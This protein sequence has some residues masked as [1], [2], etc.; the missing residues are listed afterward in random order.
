[1]RVLY[2]LHSTQATSGA[3]KALL[4]LIQQLV[5][6]GIT[7][8]FIVP[9][10]EG[11]Y[12]ILIKNNYKVYNIPFKMSIYPNRRCISDKV[13]FIPKLICRTI[14]NIFA[15]IR[16]IRLAKMLHPDIIHTNT[17]VVN[18]GRIAA[19]SLNI[20]HIQHIREYSKY[21]NHGIYFHY[22][23]SW[24]YVHNSMKKDNSCNI[25]ITKDI[26]S[27]HELTHSA[28]TVVVYDGVHSGMQKM[29]NKEKEPYFLYAGRIEYIKGLD[30][31]L[32]AYEH[33][34]ENVNHPYILYV[35]G[36]TADNLYYN[37]ITHFINC[38]QLEDYVHFLGNV[39]K[40]EEL[41]Q[42]AAALIIPSR[43]EG[44]GFCMPEAMFNGC[45]CIGNYVAGTKEQI[46]NGEAFVKEKIALSY[47]TEKELT[48]CLIKIHKTDDNHWNSIK[49]F[50][51]KT[52][53]TLYT[54]EKSA[55]V[56]FQ[57]YNN[58]IKS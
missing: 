2:I 46:D 42:K 34:K 32:H 54:N 27:H 29:P 24:R 20:P 53:N 1:M 58:I 6:K 35:A 21:G 51:F 50:A 41:M 45:L 8:F 10:K 16:I 4:G 19:K 3:T 30:I 52:V 37:E 5:P 36:E 7:P 12:N 39:D 11:V 33:Y 57:I 40:I 26:E 49:D 44:F 22:F 31:L 17:S 9:G 13:S 18:L 48:D 15:L 55:E 56:I 43:F 47:S 28:N 23:P 25:C 38:H 14:I